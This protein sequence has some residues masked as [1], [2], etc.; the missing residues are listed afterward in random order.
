[1]KSIWML[2]AS[3]SFAIM[4]AF[5]KSASMHYSAYEVMFYRCLFATLIAGAFAKFVGVSLVTPYWKEHGQ[6]AG[7][8]SFAMV[9]WYYTLGVLPMAMSVTLNYSSPIFMA[10]L[11]A[12]ASYRAT[13]RDENKALYIA[14][15]IGFLGVILLL[16]PADGLNQTWVILLGLF[17]ALMASF[18]FRDVRRLSA[19]GEPEIRLVFYFSA[20]SSCFSFVLVSLQET[21]SHTIYSASTLLLIGLFGVVGQFGLTRAFGHGNVLLSAVLQY[22]GVVFSALIGIIVWNENLTLLSWMGIAT[23]VIAGIGSVA[24]TNRLSKKLPE[25]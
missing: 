7:F 8:G 1:M 19:L 15:A 24:A 12:Y 20:Y 17:A 18:S 21:H 25:Q 14:I 6:R 5:V 9:V 11:T 23:V 2:L 13:R 22:T 10:A 3:A 4:A 16:Q